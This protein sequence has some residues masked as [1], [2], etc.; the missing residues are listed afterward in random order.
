MQRMTLNIEVGRLSAEL[1]RR[2]VEA[3]TRVRVQVEVMGEADLPMAALA[4]AGGSFDFLDEEPD[5]YSDADAV[6]RYR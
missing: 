5:L 1:A 3:R 4:Q 6:E 2:G